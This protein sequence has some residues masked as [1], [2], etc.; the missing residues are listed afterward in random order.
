MNA[1]PAVSAPSPLHARRCVRH[2][3]RE[4][5]AR[6]PGCQEFFCR[7]CVVEHD[8]RLLCRTCLQKLT[9]AVER[10]RDRWHGVRK[11]AAT[12]TGLLVLWLLFGGLGAVLLRIPPQF[13]DGSLWKRWHETGHP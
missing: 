7:E 2:S 11:V 13:H 4:A 9:L 12:T 10:R 5:A 1:N 6:C 8:G 3:D